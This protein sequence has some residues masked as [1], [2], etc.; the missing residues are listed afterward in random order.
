MDKSELYHHYLKRLRLYRNI[1]HNLPGNGNNIKWKI[2]VSLFTY[3]DERLR[4]I[5]MHMGNSTTGGGNYKSKLR[6]IKE[7]LLD[8]YIKIHFSD[9]NVNDELKKHVSESYSFNS[10]VLS[11]HVENLGNSIKTELKE[12]CIM[13]KSVFEKLSKSIK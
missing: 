7:V 6:P 4:N 13:A 2:W 9:F 8:K 3:Y 1:I 10:Y 5:D 11:F 12:A